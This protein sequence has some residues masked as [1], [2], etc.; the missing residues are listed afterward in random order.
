MRPSLVLASVLLAFAPVVRG[1]PAADPVLTK[2][3]QVC[4]TNGIE[5]C[6][7]TWYADRPKL[8]TETKDKIAG[9]TKDLGNVIDTEVVT[10]QPIT[11]R[12]TRFYVA[13]YFARRPLWL[14]VDRYAGSDQSFFL[15]LKY[16][17]ELD[18]I[19]PGYITEFPP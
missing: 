13:I 18:D 8:A 7:L 19:L 9:Y 3:L 6:V 11:K 16:S 12:L 4:L 10:V 17:I 5:A 14:R 1:A 15:P 2:G